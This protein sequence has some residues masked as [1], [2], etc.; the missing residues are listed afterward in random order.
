MKR[1]TLVKDIYNTI[2]D[3][4]VLDTKIYFKENEFEVDYIHIGTY[5]CYSAIVV[6]INGIE[7]VLRNSAI[8]II[9]FVKTEILKYGDEYNGR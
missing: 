7:S 6:S 3:N 8:D 5:D 2:S 1:F 9:K 4:N